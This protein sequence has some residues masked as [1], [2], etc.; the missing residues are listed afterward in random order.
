V[1]D[2]GF[3][4]DTPRGTCVDGESLLIDCDLCEYSGSETCDDCLITY[5]CRSDRNSVVIEL[6]DVR[7]LR[8]LGKSGLVPGL[9]LRKSVGSN[10]GR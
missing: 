8:T 7:A 2:T 10:F 1:R 5:L 6:S 4:T 3:T 9:K